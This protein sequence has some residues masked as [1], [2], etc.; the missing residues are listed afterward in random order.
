M[1]Y[2]HKNK[3]NCIICKTGMVEYDKFI[4]PDGTVELIRKQTNIKYVVFI[5]SPEK[6]EYY[7]ALPKDTPLP[8]L[9][10]SS[11]DVVLEEKS[12]EFPS[13]IPTGLVYAELDP[14]F[15]NKEPVVEEDKKTK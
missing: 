15:I 3:T 5:P 8:H 10:A 1:L 2:T 4:H 13:G 6:L 7:K 14:K 12:Q 9:R 11:V